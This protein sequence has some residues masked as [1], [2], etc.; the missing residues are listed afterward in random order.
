VAGLL[1]RG[2]QKLGEIL[3]ANLM[4]TSEAVISNETGDFSEREQRLDEVILAYLNELD[5][6]QAIDRQEW[7]DRFPDLAPELLAFFAGLD[8]FDPL[9][10]PLRRNKI[11]GDEV[12]AE[13][14]QRIGRYRVKGVLGQ[15]GFGIVYLAHS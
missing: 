8:L 3:K 15:G 13:R 1:R 12:A 4:P 11:P 6:G 14:P 5:A 2:M 10:G 7:L 9:V